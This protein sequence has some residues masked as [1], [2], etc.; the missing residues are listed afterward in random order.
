MAELVIMWIAD[1]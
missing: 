1:V